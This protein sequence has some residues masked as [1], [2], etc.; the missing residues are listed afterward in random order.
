M[1]VPQ[2]NSSMTLCGSPFVPFGLGLGLS[3]HGLRYSSGSL[4][5]IAARA[6][7]VVAGQVRDL[8]V[9]IVMAATSDARNDV[10]D[11]CSLIALKR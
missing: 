5:V 2:H 1:V 6:L 3:D 8:Q 9:V 7:A 4:P 11:R 10:V